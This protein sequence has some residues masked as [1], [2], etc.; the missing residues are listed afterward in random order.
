MKGLA[1]VAADQ[2]CRRSRSRSGWRTTSS[3]D[4]SCQVDAGRLRVLRE[5]RHQSSARGDAAHRPVE[6]TTSQSGRRRWPT[7]AS[8]QDDLEQ[9]WVSPLNGAQRRGQGRAY[10]V[11][12]SGGTTDAADREGRHGVS[13]TGRVREASGGCDAALA[14]AG[15]VSS[16]ERM[17]VVGGHRATSVRRRPGPRNGGS[18][19]AWKRAYAKG[20][21]GLGHRRASGRSGRSTSRAQFSRSSTTPATGCSPTDPGD[22]CAGTGFMNGCGSPASSAR[23]RRQTPTAI[24]SRRRRCRA[25]RASMT[26]AIPAPPGHPGRGVDAGGPA[27]PR[28]WFDLDNRWAIHH[29]DRVTMKAT[30]DVIGQLLA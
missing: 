17:Q 21:Y 27:A 24:R 22:R 14:T 12:P 19:R 9:T 11:E 16:R 29:L 25:V 8:R 20:G 5:E 7:P 28:S 10:P 13:D 26:C 4:W 3:T 2:P 23:R 15:R 30:A 1:S 6:L 18:A